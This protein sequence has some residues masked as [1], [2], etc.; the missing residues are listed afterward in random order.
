[1]LLTM[2]QFVEQLDKLIKLIFLNV[3]CY[4]GLDIKLTIMIIE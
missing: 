2:I 3:M 4:Y 1:M